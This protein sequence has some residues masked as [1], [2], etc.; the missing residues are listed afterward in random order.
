MTNNTE[1]IWKDVDGFPNYEVSNKTKIRNKSTGRILKQC[2]DSS[3]G[4]MVVNLFDSA[5][6]KSHRKY[7]HRIVAEAFI[8]NPENKRTINHIDCNKTNNDISNLEWATDSENM[9]HAFD[10][11]LC[12]NT[13]K[14][15]S[16]VAKTYNTT[17]IPTERQ[18][19]AAR[20]NII[21]INKRPKTEK[22][23][24]ASLKNINSVKCRQESN[25]SHFNRHRLIKVIETGEVYR[26]QKEAAFRLGVNESAICACLHDRRNHA[27]GYHFEY[28][29]DVP[30]RAPF[31]YPYQMEAVNKLK[32]GCVLN[33]GV[34][35]GK[36]RTGLYYYF[37][38][39]GGRID[40]DGYFP[41]V[42]PKNLLILTTA[43]KRDSLE[44]DGELAHFLLST[45]K[46]TNYYDI[47][48]KIDSWNNIQKYSDISGWFILFDEQRLCGSGTWVKTFLKMVKNN[49]WILLSATPGDTFNDYVPLFIANGF[50]KNRTEFNRNHVVFSRF[51]KYPKIDHYYNTSLLMKYRDRILVDMNFKRETKAHHIDIPVEYDIQKYKE[52]GKTRW[53]PFKDEPIINASG[54]CYVWRRIVNTDVSRQVALMELAE[55]HPRI[56]VFY[57]FDHELKILRELYYGKGFQIAEYNGHKHDPVPDCE[58]WVYLVNYSAGNAGWNCIKTNVI[59]F[60]SQNYSYKVMQQAAGRIDRLNTPFT[61]LYYYH[62]KSKSGIDLA[63]SR[64]LRDKRNF[65][66]GK[67]VKW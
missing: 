52:A 13:R 54:L 62:L 45:H 28:T 14:S 48:V 3:I 25:E 39:N 63:I 6:G 64:A 56:I 57:N 32:N 9:K 27:K 12:E 23:L 36:S 40:E 4:Y 1:E 30:K 8:P 21:K 20:E 42:N 2:L 34:G 35:S 24:E 61:D 50:F 65:N 58:K 38:E 22:Q 15:A 55:K 44:W 16:V 41:M 17:R 26:S 18:R 37:K 19:Q 43:Q 33:G 5:T 7:V 67:F 10:N 66:E 53:D 47:E 49:D 59:V 11:G 46:D 29:D 60:Y 31:L 51:T